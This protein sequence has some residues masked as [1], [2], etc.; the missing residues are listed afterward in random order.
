[1]K[2][3]FFKRRSKPVRLTVNALAFLVGGFMVGVLFSWLRGIPES[4]SQATKLTVKKVV[5][6]DTMLLSDNTLV[7][8]LGVEAPEYG[9]P[10][11]LQ[12]KEYVE[13]AVGGEAVR[14]ELDPCC[15]LDLHGR[16]LA[17]IWI[18]SEG[19]ERLLNKLLLD[20]SL[21]EADRL[22]QLEKGYLAGD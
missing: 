4:S 15:E 3:R 17:Y 16:T 10:G 20:Q 22:E 7:R 21:A 19:E 9:E 6:G 1:M 12:V 5:D 2:W 14:L 13:E 18:F 11:F 8:L